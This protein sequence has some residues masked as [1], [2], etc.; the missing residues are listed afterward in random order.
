MQPESSHSKK[1]KDDYSIVE[2]IGEGAYGKVMLVKD[3]ESKLKYAMKTIKKNKYKSNQ[4][5]V[6]TERN[7]LVGIN[8]PFI[9]KL[10]HSF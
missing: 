4:H 2:I 5:R 6:I 7:V 3:K 8:H 1:T 9:I 10:H